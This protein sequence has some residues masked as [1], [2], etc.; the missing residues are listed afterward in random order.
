MLNSIT[1]GASAS[2]VQAVPHACVLPVKAAGSISIHSMVCVSPGFIS[3]SVRTRWISLALYV[4]E[5]R[6]RQKD[7]KGEKKSGYR[8]IVKL[9]GT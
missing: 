3:S 4:R 8:E 5:L 7:R 9:S 1:K 6:E 2:S